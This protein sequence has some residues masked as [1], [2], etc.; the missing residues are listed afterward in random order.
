MARKTYIDIEYDGV[1]ITEDISDM[2]IDVD[3]S[4][5]VSGQMDEIQIRV[6]DTNFL[7]SNGWYPDQGSTVRVRMG[8]KDVYFDP[9]LLSIDEIQFTGPPDVAVI[10]AVSVPVSSSLRTKRTVRYE[11]QSLSN[12]VNLVASRSNLSVFG[13]FRGTSIERESQS[14]E[15]DISFLYRVAA[16]FGYMFNIKDEQIIFTS[17]YDLE[18]LSPVIT[19]DRVELSDYSIT[20]KMEGIFSSARVRFTN[21][22]SGETTDQEITSQ[23]DIA[24]LDTKNLWWEPVQLESQAREVARAALHAN[25]FKIDGFIQIEG[26]TSMVAGNNFELTGMGRLSGIYHILGSNHSLSESGYMTR[27]TIKRLRDGSGQ[28]AQIPR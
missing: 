19:V 3:Y 21:P 7:W 15:S 28:R 13:Q 26:N 17:V 11:N 20:D 27:C 18:E 2:I 6:D 4:D 24:N 5:F 22:I 14:D 1:L 9:G 10:R 25:T 16:K 23:Q 8:Y 12:L